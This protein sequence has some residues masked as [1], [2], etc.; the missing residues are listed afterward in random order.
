[1]ANNPPTAQIIFARLLEYS[2]PYFHQYARKT[3]RKRLSQKQADYFAEQFSASPAKSHLL[4]EYPPGE[5]R[6]QFYS[7]LYKN[8]FIAQLTS[9]K[10]N[11]LP[12][13][14]IYRRISLTKSVMKRLSVLQEQYLRYGRKI[15]LVPLTFKQLCKN[16]ISTE[17]K[18]W[19]DKTSLSRLLSGLKIKIH[20]KIKPVKSL[21]PSNH[22]LLKLRLRKL[23]DLERQQN[24]KAGQPLASSD[25]QLKDK[26]EEKFDHQSSRKNITNCRNKMAI[27]NS[28]QRREQYEKSR[29]NALFTRLMPFTATSIRKKIPARSG[30]YEVHAESGAAFTYPAGESSLFYVGS[31]KN[32]RNRLRSHYNRQRNQQLVRLLATQQPRIRYSLVG[33]DWQTVERKVFDS[34][35]DVYGSYPA[36]NNLRPPVAPD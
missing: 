5:D 30:I 34:F 26:L 12:R 25:R 20:K 10:N 29:G 15:T 1:M 27:P 17:E 33:N 2:L 35:C 36:G 8:K 3:L 7:P 4:G 28:Y 32:I 6:F 31:S 9:I 11:D 19:W 18:K 21:M 13:K 23:L 16:L 14:D 24:I 22:Y